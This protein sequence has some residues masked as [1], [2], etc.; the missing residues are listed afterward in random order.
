MAMW[1]IAVVGLAP[2]QCFSPGGIHTMS[3]GRISS[4]GPPQR[5][6]RPQP[7]VTIK[8]WP[9]GWVCHVVRAPG[10]KVT[11][12]ATTRAGAGALLSGSIRTVPVKYSADPLPEGCEPLRLIS[13]IASF[14]FTGWTVEFGD[15]AAAH[16]VQPRVGRPIDAAADYHSHFGPGC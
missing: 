11:L 3:P 16:Y 2:C 7:A 5:R 6:A 1:V 10:S 8:V 12:T 15:S 14:I 13:M 4:I 9:S